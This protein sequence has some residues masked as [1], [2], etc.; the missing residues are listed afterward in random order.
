M[1]TESAERTC[2]YFIGKTP[3]LLHGPA[4]ELSFTQGDNVCCAISPVYSSTVLEYMRV[5][6][7][8][9]K[10]RMSPPTEAGTLAGMQR[11][12]NL[13]PWHENDWLK[14]GR[15]T[16]TQYLNK[17]H[18]IP[19]FLQ[20]HE[21]PIYTSHKLPYCYTIISPISKPYPL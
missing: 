3:R 12:G 20:V 5:L 6:A 7:N 21:A 17:R 10:S 18:N 11:W 16:T 14:L 4:R 13:F 9:P 2:R 15:E 1:E 19:A 8:I